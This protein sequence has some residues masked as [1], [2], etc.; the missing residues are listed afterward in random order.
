LELAAGDVLSGVAL[1]PVGIVADVGGEE[2][3][4]EEG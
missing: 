1:L 4:A 3:A 2:L